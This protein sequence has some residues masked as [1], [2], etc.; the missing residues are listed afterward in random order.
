MR[1]ATA[2]GGGTREAT[3]ATAAPVHTPSCVI[4]PERINAQ[5]EESIRA[6]YVYQK[7]NKF[8]YR[9]QRLHKATYAQ[10]YLTFGSIKVRCYSNDCC[11]S[12]CVI[13]WEAPENPKSAPQFHPGF[14]KFERL[15]E[16]HRALF[17]PLPPNELV[18]R[19]GTAVLQHLGQQQ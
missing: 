12:C 8:C 15:A 9:L 10:L 11:D 5:F 13:P 3:A 6:Y 7:Q 14:P 16:I 1:A 17:P 18:R 2:D 4:T 19:Y